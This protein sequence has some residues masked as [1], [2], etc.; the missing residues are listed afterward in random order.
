[1]HMG[2]DAI[3]L[4]TRDVFAGRVA[5]PKNP[6]SKTHLFSLSCIPLFSRLEYDEKN[7]FLSD[8]IDHIP[9]A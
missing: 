4:A 3:G 5:P 8:S 6:S 2:N 1:M 9:C 7:R